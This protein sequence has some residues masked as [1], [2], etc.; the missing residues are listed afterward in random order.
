MAHQGTKVK[1]QAKSQQSEPTFAQI[2]FTLTVFY[3]RNIVSSKKNEIIAP[4]R[5]SPKAYRQRRSCIQPCQ[6]IWTAL[7]N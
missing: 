6:Y 3:N 4:R 7:N 1:I 2:K 5:R